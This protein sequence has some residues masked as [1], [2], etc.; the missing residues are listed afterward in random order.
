MTNSS[1]ALL[2]LLLLAGCSKSPPP[3]VAET[4]G[5]PAEVQAPVPAKS[6]AGRWV[7]PEG[8][9]LDI[10]NK[11]GLYSG[12]FTVTNRYSLDKE[13]VFEAV[14]DGNTLILTRNGKQLPVRPGTGDETGMKWLAGKTDCLII[15]PGEG[16]CRPADGAAQN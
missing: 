16:Y 5:Y 3:A 13:G 1:T 12:R 2:A 14:A 15:A 8:M 6:W 10:V 4:L 11:D 9:F 7:G